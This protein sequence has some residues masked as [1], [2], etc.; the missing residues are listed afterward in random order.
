MGERQASLSQLVQAAD[1]ARR[2]W[3]RLASE[4]L[5]TTASHGD[6]LTDASKK[7]IEAVYLRLQQAKDK[8]LEALGGKPSMRP[9]ARRFRCPM[10]A[11]D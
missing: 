8:Y 2:E 3:E 10:G 11:L 4:L 9:C 7:A 5:T 6:K 1:E